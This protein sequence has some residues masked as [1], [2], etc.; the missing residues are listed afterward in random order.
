M[1]QTIKY[2]T[3]KNENIQLK[4]INNITIV[5]LN[6][7]TVNYISKQKIFLFKN[8][9]TYTFVLYCLRII[10]RGKAYRVRLFKKSCKFTF[11][12]GYSHWYKLIYNKN[13]FNF[14]RIRRQNYVVI[15]QT[16]DELQSIKNIFNSIRIY[17]RYTRRG[18]RLKKSPY[19]K[20]FGKVS[21]VNSILHSF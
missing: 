18:I 16:R 10:W 14:T 2:K 9:Y 15:F 11:S 5:L 4:K 13:Y 19:L 12:F 20:R 1:L 8:Y 17:N 6:Y 21:Q 7:L 3:I